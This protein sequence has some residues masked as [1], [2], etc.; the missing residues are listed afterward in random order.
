MPFLGSHS[1]REVSVLGSSPEVTVALSTTW[2]LTHIPRAASS[3]LSV[4]DTTP[5]LYY[6]SRSTGWW[7]HKSVD[8]KTFHLIFSG[9]IIMTQESK[10]L[11]W[12]INVCAFVLR[13]RVRWCSHFDNISP[14]YT[15]C[16]SV[17]FGMME[18]S[19]CHWSNMNL[20]ISKKR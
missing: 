15:C 11:H 1:S 13:E 4:E 9:M 5:Y 12:T 2:H 17:T 14:V 6:A 16:Q 19:G 10:I 18:A 3:G 20:W 8:S 7:S